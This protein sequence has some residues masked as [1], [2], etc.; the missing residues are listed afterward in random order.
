MHQLSVSLDRFSMSALDILQARK[1]G[2]HEAARASM[3]GD[4]RDDE[5]LLIAIGNDQDKAAFSQIFHR[6]AGRIHAL[7]MKITRNE[8]LSNDLVQEAMLIIWQKAPL[9]DLD[10]GSAKTW[11]FT[12]VRNRCFDILRKMKRQPDGVSAEDVF[13]ETET[14]LSVNPE[15]QRSREIEL[16]QIE[17]H[18]DRLPEAQRD[19]IDYVYRQDLTH[20]EAARELK[21]PLGTLKSRLR[22]A[23]NRLRDEIGV[24]G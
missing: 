21:I 16:S 20:Q 15:A 5:T 22:L 18:F 13:S 11:I 19:V 17:H 9:Y 4:D 14:D 3:T 23:L 24:E 2:Q 6:F 8:Q 7:G 1:S 10:K 12:L